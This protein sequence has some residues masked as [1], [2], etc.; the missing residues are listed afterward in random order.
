MGAA[1]YSGNF[2]II[3][4]QTTAG[5]SNDV[6]MF[7]PIQKKWTTLSGKPT[8]VVDIHAA[9]LGE[10]IYVPG[11]KL[12]EN[13]VTSKLEVYDPRQNAWETRAALP[14]GVSAYALTA[15]EGKLYLFGG[16]MG[17]GL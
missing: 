13:E 11:G 12:S 3:G 8:A 14:A 5:I 15:Y 16:W 17:S 4:G 9:L 2:F 7:D 1:T 10:R 6:F